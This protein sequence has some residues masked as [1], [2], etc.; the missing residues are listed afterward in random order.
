M[1]K[2]LKKEDFTKFLKEL[3]KW[4]V[5]F[6]NFVSIGRILGHQLSANLQRVNELFKRILPVLL[7]V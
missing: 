7:I 1:T 6:I 2:R 4:L 3:S 5:A